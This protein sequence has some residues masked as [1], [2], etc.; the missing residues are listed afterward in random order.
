MLINLVHESQQV[1]ICI[2]GQGSM[3]PGVH[4]MERLLD[5]SDRFEV[6]MT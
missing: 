1:G 5:I 4:T 6:S 3:I 2:A